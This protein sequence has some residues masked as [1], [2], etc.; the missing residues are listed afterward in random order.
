MKPARMLAARPFARR[1]RPDTTRDWS[2]VDYGLT[3]IIADAHGHCV[4]EFADRAD[5]EFVIAAIR[6]A[7]QPSR[8]PD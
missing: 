4:A 8:V 1:T 6:Q 5:A 2:L 3:T 7:Q